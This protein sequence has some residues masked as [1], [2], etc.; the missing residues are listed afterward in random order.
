MGEVDQ[1]PDDPDGAIALRHLGDE[2]SIDLDLVHLQRAQPQQGR[3][4]GAEVVQ[5]DRHPHLA[6]PPERALGLLELVRDYPLGDLELQHAGRQLVLLELSR[7]GAH[8]GVAGQ[9]GRRD[10]HRDRHGH[11]LVAPARHLRECK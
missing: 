10:V 7:D 5:A 11:A 1:R 4:A 3:V 8:Q 9:V 6:Q 2:P